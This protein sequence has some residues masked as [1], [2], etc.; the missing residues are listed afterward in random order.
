MSGMKQG[1]A[2]TLARQL[3]QVMSGVPRINFREYSV[4]GLTGSEKALLLMLGMSE[5]EERIGL[6][7]SS[8]SN[9]LRITPAGVT[10]LLNP[11]EEHGYI[12]RRPDQNDRRIVRIGLTRKGERAAGELAFDAQNQLVG[13]VQHLG[14]RDSRHLINLLTRSVEYFEAAS[15]NQHSH[16]DK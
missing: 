15:G 4:E 3:L 16:G 8:L 10:H 12:E 14:S 13:L 7:A 9:L 6:T 11:L 1:T 2:L 5:D